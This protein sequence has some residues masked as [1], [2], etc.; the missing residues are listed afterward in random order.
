[1][2]LLSQYNAR[3]PR[4]TLPEAFKELAPVTG[5]LSPVARA[6][7]DRAAELIFAALQRVARRALPGHQDAGDLVT[8]AFIRL[9]TKGPREGRDDNPATSGQVDAFLY[10]CL[11]NQ[12]RDLARRT[13]RF[14]S[15]DDDVRGT[16][17]LDGLATRDDATGFEDGFSAQL[18]SEARNLLD[19]ATAVLYEDALPQLAGQMKDATTFRRT[20]LDVRDLARDA[21][22]IG[23][24]VAREGLPSGSRSENRLYKRHERARAALIARLRDW[25]DDAGLAP[26]L[27]EAVRRVAAHD[28]ASRVA[29]GGSPS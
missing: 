13:R 15:V 9:L 19:R 21:L 26:D 18:A 20:V 2:R 17:L 1:M 6:R 24:V 4:M 5:D 23:D 22:T 3:Q 12:G 29:R 28:M 7:R 14:D 16:R 11:R 10:T 25:L 8:Q 27:D